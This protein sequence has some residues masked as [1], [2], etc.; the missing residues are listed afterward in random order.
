MIV[1]TGKLMVCKVLHVVL[2][3]ILHFGHDCLAPSA[4]S[5]KIGMVYNF[6]QALFLCFGQHKMAVTNALHQPPSLP[7]ESTPAASLCSCVDSDR[8]PT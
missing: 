3:V 6:L 5:L 7:P 2:V 4:A 1:M 8:L